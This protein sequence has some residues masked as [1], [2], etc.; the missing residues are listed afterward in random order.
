MDRP[1]EPRVLDRQK[2]RRWIS[3]VGGGTVILSLW[4]LL[5][6]WVR[7]SV[8]RTRITTAR[9]GRGAI[10]VTLS[11]AGVVLPE[12]E[13]TITAPGP[14]RVLR[15]LKQAGDSVVA[16]EPIL[17][18]DNGASRLEVER[19]TRQMAVKANEREQAR[20][21]QDNRLS[22]LKSQSEI[23]NLELRSREFEVERN[24]KI[25]ELGVISLD[26]LRQSQSDAERLR[27]EIDDLARR[28]INAE[29]ALTVRLRSLDLEYDIL[30]KEQDE[31]AHVLS[32]GMAASDMS[33]VI[34]WVLGS[35]GASVNQG[36]ELA[37]VADLAR[38]KV[39]ATLSDAYSARIRPGQPAFVNAGGVR[40]AGRVARVLP[41]VENG[42]LSLEIALDEKSHPALRHNLRVEAHLVVDQQDDA[43]RLVRGSI[44]TVDNNQ[45]VF[46]RKGNRAIRTLAR[47]GRTGWDATE[48]LEGLADGDEVI[49]SDMSDHASQKEV[50]IQ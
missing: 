24:R 39:E 38:F 31:A 30:A 45:Y 10:D 20:V 41:T 1:I 27:I 5:P 42:T 50:R 36:D 40:L 15:V 26:V 4:L 17:E 21:D 8:D 49:L 29:R 12:I 32:R 43:L 37:R 7:P 14:S 3:L 18:M 44:L 28:V 19:L 47:F 23:K 9:V 34:T 25:H 6:G 13:R 22:E 46:V 16:G 33:G 2:R 11:A 48:V 35:E